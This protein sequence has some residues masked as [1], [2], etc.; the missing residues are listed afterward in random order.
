VRS[1]REAVARPAGRGRPPDGSPYRQVAREFGDVGAS[2]A[3]VGCGA[4][5][6]LLLTE[7]SCGLTA[8]GPADSRWRLHARRQKSGAK[9]S[10]PV[11]R[12]GTVQQEAQTSPVLV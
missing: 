9:A 12:P 7:G 2:K 1:P 11:R 8:D 3:I 4:R 10:R 5:G 6:R